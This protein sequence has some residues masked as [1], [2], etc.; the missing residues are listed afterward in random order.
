MRVPTAQSYANM[1]QLTLRNKSIFEHY[2]FQSLTGIKSP[3]YAGFGMQAFN[4]VSLEA[5]LNITN[6]FLN[7]NSITQTE[8]NMINTSL[9]S[10]YKRVSEL[11]S[12]MSSF[13]AAA[14]SGI[15]PDITGGKLMFNNDTV[16]DYFNTTITVSGTQY[17]FTNGAGGPTDIDIS[18]ATN[19]TDVMNA[20]QATVGSMSTAFVFNGNEF[21]F[22]LYTINGTSSVLNVSDVNTGDPVSMSQDQALQLSQLQ[23][24]AFSTMLILADSLNVSINGRFLYG[25]G[26]TNQAPINFPFASLEQ[27]QNYYDGINIQYPTTTAANLANMSVTGTDTGNLTLEMSGTTGN[28]A[29]ITAANPGAFLKEGITANPITTGDLTFNTTN[30]TIQAVEHGAFNRF[31][32]GDTLVI[33]GTGAGANAQAYIITGI[34]ADGKTITVDSS[35]PVA[36]D[37]TITPAND[38]T[39]NTSFPVGSVI[40]MDGFPTAV[41]PTVQVTGISDDGSTLYVTTDPNHFPPNGSPLTIPATDSWTMNAASYYTGGDLSFER[42]ISESQSL[43]FDITG[44]DPAFEQ[45]FRALGEI[46]QGNLVDTRSPKDD[47]STLIDSSQAFDRTMRALDLVYSA[48][49]NPSSRESNADLYNIMAKATSNTL[50]LT[51]VQDTQELMRVNLSNDIYSI[52]HVNQEEAAVKALTASQN[53]EASFMVL[54][55]AINIS[56][57]NYLQ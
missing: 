33:G 1:L 35:T 56:L 21:E 22:P 38:V 5:S 49:F 9:D 10:V 28:A 40:R 34:S 41:A 47:L 11:K 46:A 37:A 30:N 7:N 43:V 16:S 3:T 55:R 14:T 44:G 2:N 4:V 19:G 32:P 45:L 50:V 25:G 18:A 20:L 31:N 24:F 15:T 48:V 13:G 53:L 23:S 17:T 39:L 8:C 54:Q 26:I 42:R 6:N 36:A 51:N 57:L 27:F 12:I 29:T 52:K